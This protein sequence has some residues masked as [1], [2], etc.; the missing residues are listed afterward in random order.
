MCNHIR[1]EFPRRL[2]Y[3][4]F[5]KRQAKVRLHQLLLLQTCTQGKCTG[6]SIIDSM[7]L[8]SCHIKKADGHRTM[9]GLAA[10]GKSTMGWL[11]GFRLH[12]EINDSGEIIHMPHI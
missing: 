2:S 10:K 6:I 8:V 12:T 3:N 7:P 5:A 11:Y 4:R 9:S 1:K